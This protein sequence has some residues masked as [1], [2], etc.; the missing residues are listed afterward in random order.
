MAAHRLKHGFFLV[1]LLATI[2]CESGGV[3][4]PD[5]PRDA[6]KDGG[7]RD[8][9]KDA[10]RDTGAVV[11]DEDAGELGEPDAAE[12]GELDAGELVE[13]D[14][15]E[16]GEPDAAEP[17]EPDAGQPGEPDAGQPVEPDAGDPGACRAFVMPSDVDCA[18]PDDGVL[19]RD[20]RCTGLYGNFDQRQVACGVLEY[21][22][23]YE[24]WSDDAQ[25]RRW[26]S[27]PAGKKVDV[28]NSDAFVFPDETLFWKE[29]RV[30]DASGTER[31]AETRLLKKTPD[32]WLYTS[33]V[34][35]AAQTEAIQMNNAV[36][37][38]SLDDTGH[39]VPT[40]DQ[41]VE[42]HGGRQDFILGWDALMLGPGA[43]GITRDKLV[44]LGLA[45]AAPA[46]A[47]PGNAVEVAALGYLHANCGISC[48]NESIDAKARESGLYL[49][50]EAGELDS[51]QDT[52]AFRSGMNKVP[53][54]NAKIAGLPPISGRWLAIRPGDPIR[55]LLVARQQQ[56]G[57]EGQMPRI[58]TN[59]IDQAG[60]DVTTAWIESMTVAGGY[61]APA[62]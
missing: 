37:V 56:R 35:N 29:F 5:T 25:K 30:K 62:R 44:E 24:L 34:W 55:S 3:S 2:A 10:S 26:V 36:G 43:E 14:A 9:G 19:P 48:H 16:P 7:R 28:S 20:L 42:C 39:T 8:G 45:D 40:R 13:L 54:T 59:V 23:A 18:P 38:P 31:L 11:D 21:K 61:P 50:L 47:I 58:G 51:V 52:D 27:M 17:G 33:Y 12:P 15:A 6:G 46:L 1:G 4:E 49:R 32:G 41:C 53:S 60:V 57:V 22:P